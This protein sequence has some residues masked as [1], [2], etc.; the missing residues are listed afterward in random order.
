LADFITA[1]NW[2]PKKN[3]VVSDTYGDGFAEEGRSLQAAEYLF[4]VSYNTPKTFREIREGV[5][6]GPLSGA[7]PP[8]RNTWVGCTMSI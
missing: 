7:N 5:D 2:E 3:L 8:G 4:S 1:S 6:E